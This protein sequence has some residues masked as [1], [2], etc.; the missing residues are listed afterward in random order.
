MRRPATWPPPLIEAMQLR[1]TLWAASEGDQRHDRINRALQVRSRPTPLL[2]AVFASAILV[3]GCGG[4]SPSPIG[5]TAVSTTSSPSTV[6]GASGAGSGS[7]AAGAHVPGPLAFSKCMRANGVPNFPDLGN[8]G[9]RI[10]GSG[11]TLSV[12]GISV[13]APAFMAARQTCEKYKPHTSGT[14]TAV[15]A[16]QQHEEGL[17]FARCMRSH[18]VPNFPDPKVVSSHGGNQTVYLPG[19]NPH[20]PAFQTAAKA[21]SGGPK[22]P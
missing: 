16:A 11:Q 14:P 17:K 7:T 6:A 2:A 1:A 18:G 8:N 15:Q 22:G 19:I 3:T 10:E 13:S 20:A 9:I 12:N 4:S 5:A 21:C